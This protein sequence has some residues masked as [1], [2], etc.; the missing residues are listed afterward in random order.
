MRS[1]ELVR[2]GG[3]GL[4]VF[5]TALATAAFPNIWE[6]KEKAALGSNGGSVPYG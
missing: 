6:V 1:Q 3:T 4:E 5:R 2:E